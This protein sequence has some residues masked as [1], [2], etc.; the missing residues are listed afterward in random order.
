MFWTRFYEN[1]MGLIGSAIILVN[2]LICLLAPYIATHD[3]YKI[4]VL[5]QTERPSAEFW[6]GTDEFGRDIFSRVIYGGRISIYISFLTV[7]VA[8]VLGVITGVIA[9]YY[10][11][12]LDNILMR[13]MDALMSF[14]AILLAIGIMGVLGANVYNVVIALGVVYMPRFA[15]LLRASALP[16]K[17]KEFVEA[18][19]ALGSSDFTIIIRHILPNSMAPLIVQATAFLAYAVLAEAVLSF[20]GL[21]TPP[22]TPSWGCILSEARDFMLEN[23]YMTMFPGLAITILVLGLNLFG[24]ALRDILDPRLK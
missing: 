6:F 23:P 10:G 24:D 3:P 2:L 11:G 19:R 14:P 15:R 17:E 21:G 5:H 20:L 1:R 9:G 8:S 12:W 22:P 16:L 18:S 4:D 7:L 13:C